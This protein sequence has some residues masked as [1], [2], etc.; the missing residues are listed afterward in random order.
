MKKSL[1]FV[2]FLYSLTFSQALLPSVNLP[3]L[4]LNG[5]FKYFARISYNTLIILD[6]VTYN[7]IAQ[8]VSDDYIIDHTH[9]Y[10]DIGLVEVLS[11]PDI[12]NNGTDDFIVTTRIISWTFFYV[13]Y[14]LDIKNNIKIDTI[15]NN[16]TRPSF[17][18]RK[19]DNKLFMCNKDGFG[20]VYEIGSLAT[21][22]E[23]EN[24]S[25]PNNLNLAQNYPNPFN[26]TTKIEY[27]VQ[28][29]ENIQIKIYNSV[30]QLVKSLI[31]E[32]KTPGEYSVIWESE[33]DN[34]KKVASGVYFY[35]L[36]T[37]DFVS[38]KKMIL[39]K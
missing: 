13:T 39:L 31:N 38:S 3:V 21:S 2:F 17:F 14:I 26:P 18:V 9:P 33:D 27:S 25:Q 16:V 23:R 15:S 12:N 28:T 20:N 1:L 19:T 34:G 11:I 32:T 7:V 37:K 29:T 4:D 10:S 35:Q 22:I 5:E 8:S 6:P 36:Q 24:N 30:G